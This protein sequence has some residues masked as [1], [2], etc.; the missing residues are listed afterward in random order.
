M[1]CSIATHVHAACQHEEIQ[2]SEEVTTA[3]SHRTDKPPFYATHI[4][5][6]KV[7]KDLFTY[8]LIH[9]KEQLHFFT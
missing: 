3:N 5:L 8:D 2:R 1:E 4:Y 9:I 7:K 6:G